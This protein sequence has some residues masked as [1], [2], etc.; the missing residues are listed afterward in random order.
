MHKFIPFTADYA[1]LNPPPELFPHL[2]KCGNG[3]PVVWGAGGG[4]RGGSEG[5]GDFR[6]TGFQ[7]RL[8][9]LLL[10]HRGKSS[11]FH[12]SHD[13]ALTLLFQCYFANEVIEDQLG[14]PSCGKGCCY[15]FIKL[16]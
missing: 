10:L 14:F 11:C 2:Y 15:D 7:P 16:L 12:K 6:R 4:M 8:R 1:I 3:L 5:A 9:A 13:S